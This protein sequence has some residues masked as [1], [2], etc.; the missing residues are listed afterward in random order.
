MK[1]PGQRLRTITIKDAQA[2]KGRN[3][4]VAYFALSGLNDSFATAPGAALGRSCSHAAAPGFLVAPL[5]G[6]G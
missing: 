3:K 4:R 2:L 1:E 5:R 6:F